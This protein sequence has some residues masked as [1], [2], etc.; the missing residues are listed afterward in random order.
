MTSE[1]ETRSAFVKKKAIQGTFWSYLS[2]IVGK[3]LSFITTII[4]ARL[5]LPEEFGLVGYATVVI[6][7]LD[8]LNTLGMGTAIISRK[9]KIEEASN[10]AF[11]SSTILSIVLYLLAWVAAPFAAAYFSEPAVTPLLRVIALTLP[12]YALGA[13]PGAHI[14]KNLRFKIKII[15]DFSRSFSKGLVSVVLAWAGFGVWSLIWGQIVSAFIVVILNWILGKWRPTRVF[16]RQVS[17]EMLTFGGHIV[18]IGFIGVL[19]NN[20]DYLIVGRVLGAAAL[21]YYTLAYRMPELVI[22]TINLGVD[23]V[24][25][26]ILSTL[27]WDQDELRSVYRNYLRY[28]SL[29]ILPAGVGLAILSAPIIRIFYSNEWLASIPVMRWIAIAVMIAALGHIP[30]V[31]YKAINRPDILNKLALIKLP[32]T[33]AILWY[34]S[35]WGMVGVA[36]GHVLLAFI[37]VTLDTVVAGRFVNFGLRQVLKTISPAFWGAIIMGAAILPLHLI[38]NFADIPKLITAI[39]LGAGVYITM[40]YWLDPGLITKSKSM[41]RGALQ[42]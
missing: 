18:A 4:L 16:D 8:V 19:L 12:I 26:P 40:V 29:A 34:G 30:G 38:P 14:Q 31:L 25:H 3:L 1:A 20:V 22:R 2:F 11:Y 35:R 42:K 7:Y 9:D 39:I 41:L 21:G 24:A 33:I 6:D 5:L 36:L 27:Q 17:K 37:K 28:T 15:P 32:L 23:R 13:I 10:I